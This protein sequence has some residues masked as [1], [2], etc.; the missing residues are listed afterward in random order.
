MSLDRGTE[1]LIRG[2]NG[3]TAALLEIRITLTEFRGNPALWLHIYVATAYLIP[4]KADRVTEPLAGHEDWHT[5]THTNLGVKKGT[6]V[7]VTSQIG[8]ELLIP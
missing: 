3:L 4:R 1:D 5:K 7:V 6:V 2:H 8:N